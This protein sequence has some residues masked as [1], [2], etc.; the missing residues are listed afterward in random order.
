MVS[1]WVRHSPK[2]RSKLK[3]SPLFCLKVLTE[4][5]FYETRIPGELLNTESQAFFSDVLDIMI[6]GSLFSGKECRTSQCRAFYDCWRRVDDYSLPGQISNRSNSPEF[7]LY[8]RSCDSGL[9]D[10]SLT[11]RLY[12][13]Y[14]TRKDFVRFLTCS[15]QLSTNRSCRSVLDGFT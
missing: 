2:T 9:T 5:P 11:D 1:V 12:H 4:K 6:A 13:M 8:W 3:N 15:I 10:F 7:P 14:H